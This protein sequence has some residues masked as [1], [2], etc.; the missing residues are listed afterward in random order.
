[1]PP[2]TYIW[3]SRWE[4][5]QHYRPRRDRGPAWIKTHTSQLSD[6]RYLELTDRQRSLLHDLRMMFATFRGRLTH[7][8]AMLARQR[9]AQTRR[10]DV[11]ALVHAGHIEV[12]SREVLEKRLEH[13]FKSRSPEVEVEEEKEKEEPT[14]PNPIVP[15]T[16]EEPQP[17]DPVDLNGLRRLGDEPARILAAAAKRNLEDEPL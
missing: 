2:K 6:S 8:C 15:T 13:F 17:F 5:F 4:D 11:E 9:N 3:I 7:D 1:M 12:V 16:P 14:H 10:D